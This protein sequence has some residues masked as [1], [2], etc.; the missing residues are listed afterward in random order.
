MKDFLIIGNWKMN[1]T[2]TQTLSYLDDLVLSFKELNIPKSIK[3]GIAA[4]YPSL[5]AFTSAI[6][7]FVLPV[8]QNMSIHQFGAFTGEV[9]ALM[10]NDLNVRYVI[11]GHNERRLHHFETNERVNVKAKIAIEHGITPLICV[12]ESLEDYK[13]NK[14]K[15]IIKQQVL[16]TTK[17]LDLDKFII[18]YEPIWATGTGHSATPEFANEICGFISQLLDNKVIVQYGGSVTSQNI[19][20][21]CA[22]PNING[23][24]VGKA[25]LQLDNFIEVIKH[26]LKTR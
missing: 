16:E 11:L 20:Q 15:E 17:G 4:P 25:S 26:S 23:F 2:Y 21:L 14:T 7:K 3:V 13:N 1:K 24:L 5:P 10:L 18:A 9:S 8:A 12:G 19:E 6:S 22:Q